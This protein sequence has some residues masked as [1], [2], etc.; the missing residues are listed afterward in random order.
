MAG[1]AL[2]SRDDEPHAIHWLSVR[3]SQ[4]RTGVAHLLMEQILQRW[5][6]GDVE[7]TTFGL[8]VGGGAAARR[9]YTRFGFEAAG[10]GEP[11]PNG[12]SRDRYVLRR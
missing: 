7:V 10:R 2:L 9:L 5:P 12:T 6:I 11:G 4:R 8:D 1:A 3:S